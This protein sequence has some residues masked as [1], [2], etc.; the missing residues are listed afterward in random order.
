VD[1]KFSAVLELTPGTWTLTAVGWDSDGQ[2]TAP[3]EVTIG[4]PTPALRVTIQIKGG[5][6]WLKIWKDGAVLPGYSKDFPSG[7]VITIEAN[8]SV[9]IRTGSAVKTYVT[10]NGTAY[11]PLGGARSGSWRITALGPPV[12]SQDM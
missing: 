11:G 7:T 10:V 4:V 8:E 12:P 1:G 2:A 3:V 5:R 6:A 9:W